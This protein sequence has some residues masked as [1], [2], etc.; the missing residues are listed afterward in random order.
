MV[1]KIYGMYDQDD[2]I[3][4]VGKTIC[5]LEKRRGEHI[6]EATRGRHRNHR[7]NWLRLCISQ[8]YIPVIRL[9]EE[10]NG[11]GSFEERYWIKYYRDAGFDLVNETDG[12]DGQVGYR[13]TDEAKQ[14]IS[15]ARKGKHLSPEHISKLREVARRGEKHHNFGKPGFMLGKPS[16]MLGKHRSAETRQKISEAMKGRVS[17]IKGKPWTEARRQSQDLRHIEV[18]ELN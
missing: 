9:I 11:N 7:I 12:G 8:N 16:P 5:T 14:K 6:G 18:K 1:T 13:H 2:S 3:R 17:P 15:E 10:V 4:Y